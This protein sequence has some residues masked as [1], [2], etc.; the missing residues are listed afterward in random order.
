MRRFSLA[1]MT[2]MFS[3]GTVSAQM[4][5]RPNAYTNNPG[6]WITAGISG[7]RANVVNDGASASAWDF[8]NSTNFAYRGSIERGGSNGSSFGVA[9]SWS[10]VP[11]L[12]SSPV[13]TPDAGVGGVQCATTPSC[14]A[15]LDLMTLVATF[16]SG[17]GIGFHQVLELNGG[18][19]A[20]RNLKRDLDGAKLA[21]SGGNID[22]LFALGYGFGYGL[23]D[24]TNLDI[25][26]DYSFA[27]HERKGLSNG[28]SNTNSMPALRVSLRMGF[29]GST[30]RR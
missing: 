10:H 20:Y 14:D 22:P 29:G 1:L 12:Y 19:V 23:S 21:P 26:S 5:R 2:V 3:A 7:F 30:R 17:G 11:F 9:G 18:V 13:F 4:P 25:L 8:G 24:R 15:H 6:F 16:H 27:I 28:T